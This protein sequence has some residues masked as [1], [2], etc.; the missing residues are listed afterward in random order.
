LVALWRLAL[1]D[2]TIHELEEHVI[3]KLSELLYVPHGRFIAAKQAARELMRAED[4][5]D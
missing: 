3:R 5:K 4:S 2:A 1:S